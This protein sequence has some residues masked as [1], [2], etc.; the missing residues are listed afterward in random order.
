MKASLKKNLM[1]QNLTK[2]VNKTIKSRLPNFPSLTQR[3][4]P[5][6]VMKKATLRVLISKICEFMEAK[7]PSFILMVRNMSVNFQTA[8]VMVREK[9]VHQMVKKCKMKFGTMA[10]V[11]TTEESKEAQ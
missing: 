11:F 8:N 2:K 9:N 7:V 5:T 4:N 10:S 6:K 3:P 1:K